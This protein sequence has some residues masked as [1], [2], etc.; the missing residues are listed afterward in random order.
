MPND[1]HL[2]EFGLSFKDLKHVVKRYQLGHAGGKFSIV[3]YRIKSFSDVPQGI[4][5]THY[6]IVIEMKE[7]RVTYKESDSSES[8]SDGD[9]QDSCEERT[10]SFFMKRVPRTH[11]GLEYTTNLG[12]FKK[13]CKLYEQLIPRLQDVAIGHEPW[14]PRCYF[15]KDE[16]IIIL[17]NLTEEGFESIDARVLDFDHLK[18][19]LRCLARMHASSIA[20]EERTR[21]EVDD[22]YR[23]LLDEN[24]YPPTEGFRRKG[25]KVITKT[26][27]ELVKKLPGYDDWDRNETV[28]ALPNVINQIFDLVKPSSKYRNVVNQSDLWAN[29]ILFK[30]EV[31]TLPPI[32][33]GKA[34]TSKKKPVDARLV[35]FQFSRYVPP[36]YDISVLLHVSTSREFRSQ[37]DKALLKEYYKALDEDLSLFGFVVED[38]LPEGLFFESYEVYKKAGLLESILYDQVIYFPLNFWTGLTWSSEKF[39]SFMGHSHTEI[40]LAAFDEHEGYRDKMTELLVELIEL[41]V[42]KSEYNEHL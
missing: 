32:E 19:A 20:L 13:E 39:E 35:D 4:L 12:V 17:Q 21:A 33:E 7:K 34:F 23:G 37:Y 9:S 2:D 15:V 16:N 8:H 40:C 1:Y 25:V 28:E 24:G 29:N 14:A 41:Y 26:L 10:C 6:L 27:I 18:I 31:E 5:A 30:Y 3:D 38:I 42:L 22:L 36:T 11:F